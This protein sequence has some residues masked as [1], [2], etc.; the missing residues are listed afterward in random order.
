M[1][2]SNSLTAL[3]ITRELKRPG[4]YGDGGGLYLQIQPSRRDKN[5]KQQFLLSKSWIFRYMRARVPHKMG[6]GP[7]ELVSLAEARDKALAARKLLLAGID[8]IKERNKKRAEAAAQELHSINFRECS[9]RYILAHRAGWKNAVHARQWETTLATYA[10]PILGTLA[11]GLVDTAAIMRVLEQPIS[12]QA[13]DKTLLA[14]SSR[15]SE[16]A[17]RTHRSYPRLGDCARISRWRESSALAWPHRQA[18]TRP[19]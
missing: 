14:G 9:E 15:D 18:P 8:P 4:L 10:Y 12:G 6:L 5:N 3:K 17:A 19:R 13:G 11:V 7:L 1:R 16:Q 2:N